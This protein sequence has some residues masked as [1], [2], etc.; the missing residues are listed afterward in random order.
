M[1]IG[2]NEK[3]AA[4]PFDPRELPILFDD[5]SVILGDEALPLGP[6]LTHELGRGGGPMLKKLITAMVDGTHLEIESSKIARLIIHCRRLDSHNRQDRD[7][8]STCPDGVYLLLM[9]RENNGGSLIFES[10][11]RSVQGMTVRTVRLAAKRL[12]RKMMAAEYAVALACPPVIGK[13]IKHETKRQTETVDSL[14]YWEIDFYPDI[15]VQD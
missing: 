5:D 9:L 11:Y 14:Q 10:Y 8:D 1:T 12:P 15:I 3:Q 4:S 13:S 7:T 2:Q 6:I